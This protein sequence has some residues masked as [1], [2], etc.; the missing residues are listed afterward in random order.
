MQKSFRSLVI[1]YY[2]FLINWCGSNFV[3]E[4][5]GVARNDDTLVGISR[6]IKDCFEPL[7]PKIDKFFRK[8]RWWI[9]EKKVSNLRKP[10]QIWCYLPP[11]PSWRRHCANVSEI[12]VQFLCFFDG[13]PDVRLHFFRVKDL[14]YEPTRR[15]QPSAAATVVN[16]PTSLDQNPT[17]TQKYVPE[18]NWSLI[19]VVQRNRKL[20]LV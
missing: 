19:L 17:Q 12:L 6:S 18:I 14:H 16:G 15:R 20:S 3:W 2:F 5:R 11:T 1:R 13:I 8:L 7:S 4:S 10:S 9:K